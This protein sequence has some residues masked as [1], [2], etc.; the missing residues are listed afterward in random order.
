MI[1]VRYCRDVLS[2]VGVEKRFRSKVVLQGASLNVGAGESV[3]V[4]GEN[5]SGKSTFLNICA[6]VIRPDSGSVTATAP[7][8]FCPQQPGL[9]DLL[10]ADDHLRL[11]SAAVDDPVQAHRR[12]REFLEYLGHDVSDST[13]ARN[14]S[15]G[16]RQKLNLALTMVH[17]PGLLLLDEPYQGFDHGTYVNLWEQIDRWTSEGRAVVV[18]THLLPEHDRV[19]RVVK[20]S[21]GSL[22]PTEGPG[23]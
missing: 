19:D 16:Q 18:I 1:M 3:A 20:M 17:D 2:A 15:G 22:Q 12:G 10:N 9:V 14:L 8:G 4:V 11:M 6:G 7:I 5:G 21:N 13:P 23:Q